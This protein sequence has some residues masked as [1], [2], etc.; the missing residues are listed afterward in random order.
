M[1]L[2][3]VIYNSLLKFIA[4]FPY[5][6]TGR[7]G[8]FA[9]LRFGKEAT[10]LARPNSLDALAI[11]EIWKSHSYDEVEIKKGDIVVDIGAHVGGY[12]V[13]AAKHGADVVAY[14][15]EPQTYA[16]LMKNLKMNNCES[17][18]SYNIA[19]SS[20]NGQLIFYADN[21]DTILNSIYY[22]PHSSSSKE[23]K[24][25]SVSLHELFVRNK[26]KRID[27]L[28][29]DVEGAEYDILL[30]ALP[31]DLRKI[32]AI[33]ME[34]HDFLGHGHNKTELISLLRGSGFK[35]QERMPWLKR[36]LLKQGNILAVRK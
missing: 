35:V 21:K 27:V 22:Y 20:K 2:I 17:V 23:I 1:W 18:K 33:I 10:F 29:I 36:V 26:L 12:A 3:A 16:L 34:Y 8:E 6:G 28:K 24:V 32:R 7:I 15:A 31:E 4:P 19:V 13:L 25:P 5:I 14:E 11:H 9:V 30:S